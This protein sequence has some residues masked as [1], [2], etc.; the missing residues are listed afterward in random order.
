ECNGGDITKLSVM[1]IDRVVKGKRGGDALPKLLR[2][3]TKWI[4]FLGSRKPFGLNSD[5]DVTCFF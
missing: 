1:G 2:L 5:Y 4:F 3:E